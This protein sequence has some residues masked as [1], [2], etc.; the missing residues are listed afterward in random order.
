[1]DRRKTE[2]FANIPHEFRT[3]ITLTLGPLEQ[4]AGG[5]YGELPE[6]VREQVEIMLRNQERLLELINQI[7]DLAKLEAGGM[8]LRCSRLKHVNAFV[9]ER[10]SQFRSAA[11]RRGVDLRL[12]LDDSL[13]GAELYVDQEKLDRMLVNLLSNA[14]KF[15]HK[16]AIEVVT[17]HVNGAFRLTVADTGVGIAPDELPH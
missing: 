7:L 15:T 8:T 11:G 13:D 17:E 5:R 12:A 3:P 14:V 16:G 6:S 2:F 1:M 9:E 10:A 4:L